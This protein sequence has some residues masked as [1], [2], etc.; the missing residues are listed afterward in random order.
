[1]DVTVRK[2]MALRMG[3]DWEWNRWA[4]C[5]AEGAVLVRTKRGFASKVDC[6]AVA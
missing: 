1:M 6:A 5:L 3:F 2:R 4:T